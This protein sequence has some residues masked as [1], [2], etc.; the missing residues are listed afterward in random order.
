MDSVYCP[1]FGDEANG[2]SVVAKLMLADPAWKNKRIVHGA[3]LPSVWRACMRFG[4]YLRMPHGAY[5]PVRL[6]YS[7]W[8]KTLVGPI[9]RFFL[10]RAKRVLATCDAEAEWIR[11]YEPKS[12][13]EVVDVR[14]YFRGCVEVKAHRH[15]RPV[16]L[17]Y[18]GRLH[19]LKGIAYLKQAVDEAEAGSVE[20]RIENSLFGEEK[21]RAWT[22]CDVL[23]LPT[24]SENFGLVVAEA[25]ERGK[26]V[27]VTD[28][29]PAW[30][31]YD[32]CMIT[33]VRGFRNGD[34]T[35]RVRLL[36]SAIEKLAS[37]F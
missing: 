8:K 22:W 19:Q 33:Y 5:D 11:A 1:G 29:A 28:G 3:W 32:S 30:E 13:V 26:K 14:K 21:E 6:A 12:V 15:G 37:E 36:K 7:G 18:L 2:M 10:R 24:L 34:D 17:L 4:C 20:L 9:E 27:I 23:V 25:L 35:T 16:K 31:A